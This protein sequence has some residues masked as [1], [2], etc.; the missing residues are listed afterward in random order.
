M[1]VIGMW[2]YVSGKWLFL[3]G[4]CHCHLWAEPHELACNRAPVIGLLAMIA[5]CVFAAAHSSHSLTVKS[6]NPA[7]A[8]CVCACVRISIET[9]RQSGGKAAAAGDKQ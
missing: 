3:F 6:G 4:Q 8:A 9:I 1:K 2:A 7:T 5:V